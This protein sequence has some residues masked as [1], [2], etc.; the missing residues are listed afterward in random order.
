MSQSASPRT[1]KAEPARPLL[2]YFSQHQDLGLI[3]GS[4]AC[5]TV[6]RTCGVCMFS[7]CGFLQG[8][9]T[10]KGIKMCRCVRL[11]LSKCLSVMNRRRVHGEA[12]PLAQCQLD[13]HI[14]GE[15]LVGFLE[16]YGDQSR[17]TVDVWG[18]DGAH[19]STQ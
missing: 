11:F 14:S 8:S 10:S 17:G 5:E 4:G 1:D 6:V 19:I 2:I 3:P 16:L 18:P 9:P 7:P 13:A 15:T 12:P